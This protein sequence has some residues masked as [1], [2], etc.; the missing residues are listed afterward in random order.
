MLLLSGELIMT[1][2]PTVWVKGHHPFTADQIREIDE[3]LSLLPV[4]DREAFLD[5]S[6]VFPEK[7]GRAHV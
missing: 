6:N 4:E 1:E 2:S 7:I 3:K 5:M